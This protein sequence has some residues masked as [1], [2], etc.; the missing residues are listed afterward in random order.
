[1]IMDLNEA[2]IILNENGYELLDEGKFGRAIGMGALALGSLIGNANAIDQ[3]DID[4]FEKQTEIEYKNVIKHTDDYIIYKEQQNIIV[5]VERSPKSKSKIIIKPDGTFIESQYWNNELIEQIYGK[6]D[7]KKLSEI[8]SG[9]DNYPHHLNIKYWNKAIKYK[10]N[11]IDAVTIF[12][13][14]KEYKT[15]CADGKIVK[16]NY[17]FE[18]GNNNSF[19][20]RTNNCTGESEIWKN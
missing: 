12:K 19:H 4:R 10:N 20:K 16:H 15:M 11:E 13:N 14:G 6:I 3:N 7:N 5:D 9:K 17:T 8:E 1:M 18:P 2:K